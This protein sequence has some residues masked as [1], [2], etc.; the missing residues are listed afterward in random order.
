MDGTV[1]PSLRNRTVGSEPAVCIGLRTR[2]T[3]HVLGVER[4]QH[5]HVVAVYNASGDLLHPV[6]PTINDASVNTP[7]LRP[8][9]CS[10]LRPLVLTCKSAMDLF[11]TGFELRRC[12]C[13]QHQ[14]RRTR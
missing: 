12:R 1:Q 2:S 7:K 6:V 13:T 10:S 3:H 9:T 8:G 11:A 4:F 5:N 14:T